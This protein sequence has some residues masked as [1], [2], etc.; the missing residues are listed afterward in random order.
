MEERAV[1]E[2]YLS[3]YSL[4]S[5]NSFR[6]YLYMYHAAS[7]LSRIITRNY[8]DHKF[9]KTWFMVNTQM[10]TCQSKVKEWNSLK[11]FFHRI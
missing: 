8:G 11:T 6:A 7:L 5:L 3:V 2:K 10:Y 4:T 1:I 9:F